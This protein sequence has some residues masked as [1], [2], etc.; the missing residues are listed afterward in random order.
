MTT[1][2][3]KLVLPG[4]VSEYTGT[5]VIYDPW[6]ETF[7][8]VD[9]VQEENSMDITLESRKSLAVIITEEA[10]QLIASHSSQ[11]SYIIN[12]GTEVTLTEFTRSTCKALDYPSFTGS[13][14]VS[15]PDDVQQEEKDFG[16]FIRYEADFQATAGQQVVVAI[17]EAAE[18]IEVFV[19]GNSAGY[20]ITPGY[21]FDVTPFLQEG[22]NHLVIEQA[23][24]LG[25]SA[26]SGK[27][28]QRM[29]GAAHA[30]TGLSGTVKLYTLA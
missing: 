28:E 16:G 18:A 24:T 17:E 22:E 2:H 23:T 14:L 4:N 9:W 5:P 27:M 21:Y 3:G 12:K 29:R 8:S 7:V 30:I 11:V 25:L 19:N 6:N 13:K 10:Q 26:G 20:Q 15:L 1:Y